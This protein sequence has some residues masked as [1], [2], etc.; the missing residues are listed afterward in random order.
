VRADGLRVAIVPT[1]SAVQGIA[2]LAVHQGGRRFEEDVVAMTAAAGATRFAEL[3]VAEREAWTMAGVCQPGDT[4]G[5]IDGDVA[6]IG[7]DPAATAVVLLDRM[8]AAGGELVTL[9]LGDGAPA[10]LADRLRAH[11]QAHHLAVDTVV[12]HGGRPAG[13]LLIG[14]E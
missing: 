1:R 12:Y 14:V 3:A 11:V 4:L 10:G 6:V 9:V 5:M 13:P 7:Q 2:A 8:L